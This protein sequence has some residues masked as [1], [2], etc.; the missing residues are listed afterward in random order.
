MNEPEITIAPRC[1]CRIEAGLCPEEA[2]VECAVCKDLLC[3]THAQVVWVRGEYVCIC[4][5][6]PNLCGLAVEKANDYK[7]EAVR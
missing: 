7:R 6:V 5:D 4:G 2:A 3:K 1:E